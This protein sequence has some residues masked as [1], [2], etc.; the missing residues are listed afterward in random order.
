MVPGDMGRL[1]GTLLLLGVF[2]FAAC[3]SSSSSADD[4]TGSKLQL[5][6][7]CNFDQPDSCASRLCEGN[8]EGYISFCSKDCMSDADCSGALPVCGADKGGRHICVFQCPSD[9]HPGF[10]C[11][12]GGPVPVACDYESKVC[13]DCPCPRIYERC[14]AGIGC[15][16]S[17]GRSCTSAGDCPRG[18][19]LV[20]TGNTT[21][22]CHQLCGGASDPPCTTGCAFSN[23]GTNYCRLPT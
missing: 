23:D 18:M 12:L 6:D 9:Y 5:G 1:I 20:A 10:T 4:Q 11:D 17:I 22:L 19:C 8:V 16:S 15:T 3:S 21:G 2:S 14:E 7:R 13:S